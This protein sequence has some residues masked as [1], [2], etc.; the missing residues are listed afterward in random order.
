MITNQSY[1]SYNIYSYLQNLG[2]DTDDL[3]AV[4]PE[5][6]EI[7][8]VK[9]TCT[10]RDFVEKT[11]QLPYEPKRFFFEF[12]SASENISDNLEIILVEKVG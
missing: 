4:N 7:L 6:F 1:A 12:V 3:E 5:R 11:L 2:S 10:L 8:E 9:K